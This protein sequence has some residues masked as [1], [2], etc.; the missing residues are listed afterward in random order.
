MSVDKI[1]QIYYGCGTEQHKN[2]WQIKRSESFRTDRPN[3]CSDEIF[4]KNK[5]LKIKPKYC[6]DIDHPLPKVKF[7]HWIAIVI[8]FCNMSQKKSHRSIKKYG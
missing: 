6:W 1:N 3:L 5:G 8:K 2:K 4:W 7:H